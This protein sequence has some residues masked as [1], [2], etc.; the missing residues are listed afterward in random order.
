MML[1]SFTN[2]FFVLPF[3]LIKHNIAKKIYWLF[4]ILL[5]LPGLIIS[6]FLFKYMKVRLDYSIFFMLDDFMQLHL[7]K[8]FFLSYLN[9]GI[10]TWS[11][12]LGAFIFV[13]IIFV[14]VLYYFFRL[15]IKFE[16][17][18]RWV[19]IFIGIF[20]CSCI[21]IVCSTSYKSR[22]VN[23]YKSPW[24]VNAYCQY[25]TY[26]KTP[27]ILNLISEKNV[28]EISDRFKDYSKSNITGVVM[29]GESLS[30]HA[31][32]VYGYKRNTTPNLRNIMK[33]SEYGKIVLFN[34]KTHFKYTSL[35]LLHA[36][37]FS[38][39]DNLKKSAP[40]ARIMDVYGVKSYML[41][42]VYD[43]EFSLKRLFE[44]MENLG[45][46]PEGVEIRQWHDD[47]LTKLFENKMETL[48]SAKNC[49]FMHFQGSHFIFEDKYPSRFKIFDNV[50]D[51]YTNKYT[52]S[53]DIYTYNTYDNTVIYFDYIFDKI[54]AKL[55]KSEVPSFILYF[56]DHGEGP[57]ENELRGA[58]NE[59]TD[60]IYD[61]PL[62]IWFSNSYIKKYPQVVKAASHYSNNAIYIDKSIMHMIL[63]CMRIS[64][65]NEA[66]VNL[67]G[68]QT[69]SK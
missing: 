12:L 35:S 28:N 5:F 29:I 32:S 63:E 68:T 22:F 61:V 64:S 18:D 62:L 48:T 17:S 9:F 6:Y 58:K 54:V 16:K 41:S 15:D 55:N 14:K 46:I 39:K 21:W 40:I 36:L 13:I 51:A 26:K 23:F 60:R 27:N 43:T 1:E 24:F 3:L 53:K 65:R 45:G 33:S 34:G 50:K 25:N 66:E 4:T 19:A 59:N 52:N 38:E 42:S 11:V 31:M 57:T 69:N 44:G 49:V 7:I 10:I 37:S 2:V 47:N 8:D 30:R 56:S 20:L 67:L